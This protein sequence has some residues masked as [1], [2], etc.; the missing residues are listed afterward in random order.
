M[1]PGAVGIISYA[2]CYKSNNLE[3]WNSCKKPDWAPN[4]FYTCA[5]IDV[6]TV[7]PVGYASYLIYKYGIGFRNYLTALSLGLCGSKLIICFASLP[8]MKKKDIKAIYYL[9][10]AVHL[11]TTGSAIIA[12]TINRRATLLMVPY[13]L[14]TGFYTAVLYTMKNLNSKIKN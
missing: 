1:I 3:W 2:P 12:Y 14:W 6:L 13:I 4:S 5:C 10:F 9:S 8:F 7:T 11:A